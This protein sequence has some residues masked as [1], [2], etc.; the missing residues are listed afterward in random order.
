VTAAEMVAS[1]LLDLGIKAEAV[2][3]EWSTFLDNTYSNDT[4]NYPIFVCGWASS[5]EPDAIYGVQF[6]TDAEWNLFNYS[7]PEVDELL[8]EAR[9][10]SDI[11]ERAELYSQVEEILLDEVPLAFLMYHDVWN[12]MHSFVKGYVHMANNGIQGLDEVWLDK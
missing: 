12:A 1:Y 8:V 3:T 6:H 9:Q 4:N 7:N 2:P 10:K 11:N 5:G